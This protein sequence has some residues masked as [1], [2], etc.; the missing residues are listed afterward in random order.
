M[1][2][3]EAIADHS[4]YTDRIMVADSK[5]RNLIE[6]Y[7]KKGLDDDEVAGLLE[8]CQTERFKF[9]HGIITHLLGMPRSQYD[10]KLRQCPPLWR[11]FVHGISSSSPVCAL[12]PPN[13]ES[14]R[15]IHRI[16]TED[17]MKLPEVEP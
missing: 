2:Q 14:R 9:L 8:C 3:S 4:F 6:R 17:I 12:I 1:A 13:S 7:V 5:L 11:K 16:C 15:L 10:T